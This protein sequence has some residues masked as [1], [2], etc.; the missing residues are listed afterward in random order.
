MKLKY[1]IVGV[2]A[3]GGY[4]GGKLAQQ[5]EDVHFLFH[6]DFDE[7]KKNGLR[8]D[9]VNGNFIL[10]QVNAYKKVDTMPV[11]DVVL[12]CLKTTN[13]YLLKEILPHIT[14]RDS[15]VILIQNGLGIEADLAVD[16]PDLNIAGG[17]AF[18]CSSKV[19]PGHISHQDYG[20]LN[21]GSY[22]CKQPDILNKVVTD[23]TMAGVKAQVVDLQSARW[24]K[25]IWNIPYNGMTVVLGGNTAELTAHPATRSLLREMM[26]EVIT[27]YR[28]IGGK[29]HIPDE[30]A[31]QML[32]M[33]EAMTPYSPSMKLDYD[34][35]RPM[36]IEYIYSR[37][38]EEARKKGINMPCVATL[39]RQLEFLQTKNS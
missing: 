38:L 20:G 12:V 39:E 36:E 4:Y 16:F 14:H 34:F 13:N 25:L 29:E 17:L 3:L 24:K 1:G 26:T 9:S 27:A 15:V 32:Q 33:T 22:S 21:I 30:M 2:G 31:D 35:H 10:T 8:V 6:G 7:V 19:G 28:A 5:G 11:C 37:P 23:F 18:I